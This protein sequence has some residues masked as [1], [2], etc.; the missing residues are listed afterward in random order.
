MDGI[1]ID[2]D[3]HIYCVEAMAFDEVGS[4]PGPGLPATVENVRRIRYEP[5]DDPAVWRAR[6]VPMY[7]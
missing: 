7:D 2:V 5:T 6:V 4:S 3:D 1:E